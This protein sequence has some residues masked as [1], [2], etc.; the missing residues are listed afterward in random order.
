MGKQWKQWDFIFLG[1][2]ITA[3]GDCSHEIKRCLLLGRKA[4]TNLD[5]ILKSRDITLP[6]KIHLVKEIVFPV[7]MYVC[8]CWIIR[9]A[10]CWRTDAF[11]LLCCRKLLRIP[12]TARWSNQFILKENSYEYSLEGLMLKLKLQYFGHLMRRT[13]SLEK[14]VMLGKIEGGR[15]RGW[16]RMRWL[17]G[18]TD[19]MEM[20]LSKLQ[21]LVMDRESWC[22][23][24]HVI[25]KSRTWLNWTELNLLFMSK[26]MHISNSYWCIIKIID[27]IYFFLILVNYY[28]RIYPKTWMQ[29][30]N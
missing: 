9:K 27:I 10:E 2:K 20:S 23:A 22:A 25:T 11:E 5:R 7:V 18:I 15:K 28:L 17:D 8:K 14:I 16:Q 26:H 29:S 24:I 3:D 12:W 4:M 19:S 1:S 13:D 6:T 30:I 21:E